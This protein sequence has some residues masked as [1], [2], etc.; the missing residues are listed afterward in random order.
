VLVYAAEG[1]LLTTVREH[2]AGR[3]LP[4]MICTEEL[5]STGNDDDNRAAVNAVAADDLNLVEVAV[6]GPRNA[7]DKVFKGATLHP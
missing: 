2:A 5:F 3:G 6:H 4:M 7:I 1:A